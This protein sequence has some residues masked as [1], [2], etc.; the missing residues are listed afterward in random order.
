MITTI[1]T[2]KNWQ[3]IAINLWLTILP[4]RVYWNA[5]PYSDHSNIFAQ[6]K[7][8]KFWFIYESILAIF[9]LSVR[10]W[11]SCFRSEH[12]LEPKIGRQISITSKFSLQKSVKISVI[13]KTDT[14]CI[15]N[16]DTTMVESKKAIIFVTL[17]TWITL[18]CTWLWYLMKSTQV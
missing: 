18:F 15:S 14:E 3:L 10:F 16:L 13:S 2:I 17:F 1:F 9:E 6:K 12:W 5:G 8:N 4:A 11:V 7:P